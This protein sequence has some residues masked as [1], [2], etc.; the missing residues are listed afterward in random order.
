MK[1]RHAVLT[2]DGEVMECDLITW[3]QW[4]EKNRAHRIIAQ[5]SLPGGYFIST[6]FLGLNHQYSPQAEPLW[7][8]TMI[9]A[10][11]AG[12]EVFCERY[13]TLA[14][15]LAGHEEAKKTHQSDFQR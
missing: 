8:E 10:P 13:S 3:A 5:E 15:A 14:Q 9:F 1:I 4:L 11:P 6:V 12:D 7:F 2:E